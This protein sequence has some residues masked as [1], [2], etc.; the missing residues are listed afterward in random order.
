MMF[1]TRRPLALACLACLWLPGPLS[2]HEF[3]IDAGPDLTADI[4]VGQDFSGAALPYLDRTIAAMTHVSPGGETAIPARL[5]DVPAIAGL[6]APGDGLHLLT[7]ETNPAYVVFDTLPEFE[8]YLAYEGLS[9]VAEA[10]RARGLPDTEIA[11][12]YFRNARALV[13]VGPVGPGDTDRPTGLPLELVVQGTPF[14]GDGAPVD[15]RL[16]WQGA[17]V[18]D[19]QVALFH[20][21]DGGTAPKDTVRTLA[22]TDADGAVRFDPQGAGGYL[23][24]AVR[25]EPAEG[26]GSVVWQSYW[27]S[28]TFDLPAN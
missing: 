26:P 6:A 8:E 18:P 27:A 24:N 23:F 1:S 28:L 17:P 22:T 13:Q 3:W 21:P 7:I 14:G 25:V 15:L 5:G 4:R 19:T 20:L 16:T 9:L 12:E 10:H 11:E 2:A